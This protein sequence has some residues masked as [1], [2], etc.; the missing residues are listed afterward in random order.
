MA[1]LNEDTFP[2]CYFSVC[3]NRNM[4]NSFFSGNRLSHYMPTRFEKETNRIYVGC[5]CLL[6]LSLLSL[7]FVFITDSLAKNCIL[8]NRWHILVDESQQ[9]FTLFCFFFSFSSP[10]FPILLINK[11]SCY[12]PVGECKGKL[13]VA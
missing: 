2:Y 10:V 3:K 12:C 8:R 7:S 13:S 11:H 5:K 4:P 6:E 9:Y 1:C